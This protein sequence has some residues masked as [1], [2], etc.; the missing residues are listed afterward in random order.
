MRSK[1]FQLGLELRTMD[2]HLVEDSFILDVEA[3]DTIEAV[4]AKIQ[5]KEEIPT[6]AARL[7]VYA[8]VDGNIVHLEEGRTLSDYNIRKGNANLWPWKYR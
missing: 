1:S 6:P 5:A 8:S 4:K 2:V 3:S 7:C